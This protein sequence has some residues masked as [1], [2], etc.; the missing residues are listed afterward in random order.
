MCI[1]DSSEVY[2]V[3][4]GSGN[5]RKIKYTGSKFDWGSDLGKME[6]TSKNDGAAC[7]TGTPNQYWEPSAS[8][9]S[10]ST[11]VGEGKQIKVEL[12]NPELTSK[13]GAKTQHYA[14]YS[15]TD[16][17]SG[18]L[19]DI[20]LDVGQSLSYFPGPAFAHGSVVTVNYTICLLYTSDAADE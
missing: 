19:Y 3:H 8:Y 18:V 5:V 16:G 12:R 6:Q 13:E 4:N 9:S 10:Q 1:R 17:Q 7:H 20:T 14:T 11:C 2:A 15:S